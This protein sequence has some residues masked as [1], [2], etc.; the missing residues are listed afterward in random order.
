MTKLSTSAADM[1]LKL[2]L[3]PSHGSQFSVHGAEAGF[4]KGGLTCVVLGVKPPHKQRPAVV[5]PRLGFDSRFWI[6]PPYTK[7]CVIM[8]ANWDLQSLSE[9]AA[10]RLR[11]TKLTTGDWGWFGLGFSPSCSYSGGPA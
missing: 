3:T 4:A 7:T 2:T 9:S 8:N 11:D 10:V 1:A 6:A 5:H